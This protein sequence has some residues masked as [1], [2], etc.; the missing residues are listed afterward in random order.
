MFPSK[1]T[2]YLISDLERN[3]KQLCFTIK[4]IYC[5]SEINFFLIYALQFTYKIDL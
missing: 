5:N 4:I 1:K 3:I 2:N